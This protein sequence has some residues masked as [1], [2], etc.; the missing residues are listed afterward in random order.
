MTYTVDWLPSAEQELADVWTNAPDRAAVNAAS[1][2]I[3]AALRRDPLHV[4]EARSGRKRILVE[5]PLA[6]F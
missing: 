5:P 3:D 4:G 6:V 1:N 2:R